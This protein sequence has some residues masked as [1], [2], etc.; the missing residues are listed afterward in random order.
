MKNIRAS[1]IKIGHAEGVSYLLLLLVG[2]PSKYVWGMMLPIKILGYA[3]GFLFIAFVILLAI[4]FKKMPL[5]FTATV[6]VF[7]LS[8]IPFGTFFIKKFV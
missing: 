3:H 4:A 2:M 6:K 8:L 1:L 7:L 5:S